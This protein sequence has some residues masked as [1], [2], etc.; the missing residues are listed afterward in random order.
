[1]KKKFYTKSINVFLIIVLLSGLTKTMKAQVP[2]NY[3]DAAIGL[4]GTALKT[5]LHDITTTGHVKLTYAGLWTAYATTDVYPSPNNTKIWDIYSGDAASNAAYSGTAPY[6]LIY[7]T[8]QDNGTGSVEGEF[9]NREHTIPNSWWGG[10]DQFQYTDLNCLLATDKIVNNKRSSYPYGEVGTISWTSQNGSLLGT[11]NYPGISGTV[12]EPIDIF[13]GDAARIYFYFA[14]RYKDEIPGWYSVEASS[15]DIDVVFQSNGEFQTAYY[16]MLLSWH[17]ADP[18]SAKE[19]AR[20]DAVYNTN[21]KNANPF[22]D[23]PEFACDIWGGAGCTVTI[24]PQPDNYPTLFTA[25]DISDSRIDLSWTDAIGTNLPTGYLILANTTGTFTSPVDGTDPTADSDL[26]DGSALVKVAH[27]AKG[28]YSFSGLSATTQYYFQIYPYANSGTNIDFKTNPTV[29]ADDVTTRAKDGPVA[30][31]NE[32]HYDNDGTDSG[33]KIEIVIV[34]VSSYTLNNFRIDLYNGSDGATY[35]NETGSN[36]TLGN[37]SGN[38]TIYTWAYVGI[39]NGAPDGV[40]LS[41]N[42]T[43]IQFLSYEGSFDATNGTANGT[44]STDIGVSEAGTST[45]G[46]SL[47]LSGTGCTYAD[48]TWQGSAANTMGAVN[49]SQ[50]LCSAAAPEIN[51]QGNSTTIVDEDGTPALSD[52][53]DFGSTDLASGSVVRTFTIQ[54]TGSAAL[55]LT[56]SSPYVTIGGAHAADFSVTTVPSTSIAASGSTTFQ[57]TFN[58]SATGTRAAT[59]SIANSDSNENPY[60]FSIQGTGTSPTITLTGTDPGPANFVQN[61]SNN[62]FYRIKVDVAGGTDQNVTHVKFD[63][64]STGANLDALVSGYTLW[65]STDATLNTGTDSNLGT[66]LPA[67]TTNQANITF[68]FSGTPVSITSG[69][70]GYFFITTSVLLTANVG[71]TVQATNAGATYTTNGGAVATENFAAGNAHTIVL[72]RNTESDIITAG[73]EAVSV[74]S[75]ENDAA[76]TTTADGTQVWQF[77]TRD[78]GSDGTDADVL[79]TI[80]NA[81][82]ISQ[83]SGNALQQWDDIILACALF[84]GSTK[85]ADAVIPAA[86]NQIQF[87]GAPLISV[88]DNGS[89]TLSLRLS[90]QTSPN[91]EGTNLDGEDFVFQISQG[92]VTAD[93]GGSGF[94]AFTATTS[95]NGAN[96]FDVIATK[97]LFVQQPSDVGVNAVMSPAPAIEA[98]DTHGTRD[99]DFTGNIQLTSTGTMTGTTNPAAVAG[100]A[101]F[102]NITHTVVETN[103]TLSGTSGVLSGTGLSSEFDVL[104]ITVLGQ[105]DL[106]ILAVNTNIGS[107][108]GIDQIAF[109]CFQD[110]LPGTKILLTDNG[111]ERVAAGYWGGTEGVITIERTTST[112]TAGTIIVLESNQSVITDATHFTVYTCGASDANWTKG[113]ISGGSGFGVNADDQIWIMQGGTWTNSTSHYSTYDGNVLYGWSENGWKSAPGYDD[114]KGSTL[115][116]GSKCFTTDVSGNEKVKFDDPI[117][118]DFSTSTN[119]RLDWIALVNDN[120]NWDTYADNLAY[121]SGGYNYKG[122]TTCPA[123]IIDSNPYSAGIWTGT[124]NTDWFDCGNWQ[125]LIVPDASINVTVSSMVANDIIIDDASA[126]AA[127]YDNLAECQDLTLTELVDLQINAADRLDVHGNLSITNASFTMT[128][129]SILNLYG[130]FTNN[131]TTTEFVESTGTVNLLGTVGQSINSSDP[132]NETFYNLVINNSAP[133][134]ITLNASADVDGQLTHTNGLLDLNGKALTISGIYARTNGEFKGNSASNLTIDGAGTVADLY[135]TA[136]QEL[137]NFVLSRAVSLNLQTNIEVYDELNII[138]GGEIADNGKTITVRNVADINGIHSGTGKILLSNTTTSPYALQGTG[139]FGNLEMNSAGDDALIGNVIN[140]N[141]FT[142]TAG[143]SFDTGNKNM[144]V[145]GDL[146]NNVSNLTFL[147]G[148]GTVTFNGSATQTITA[149][150]GQEFYNLV[151]DNATETDASLLDIKNALTINSGD[152]FTINPGKNVTVTG[153]ITNTPGTSGLILKSDASGTASLLHSTLNI[154]ATCERYL[155]ADNWHYLFTPLNDANINILTTNSGGYDNPNFYWYDEPTPDY[156]LGSTVYNP[157]GWTAPAHNGK[158]LTDIGYIHRSTESLTYNLSGG[159]LFA[160]TKNF[161]LSYTDNG[162]GN[163]THTGKDWNYFEGWN[164]FGNPYPSAIDWNNAGIVKT[165]IENFVYYYD[166]TNDQYKC[167]GGS[168]PWDNGITVNGGSQYIPANQGFF[169]KATGTGVHGQTF[170]IPNTARVHNG[171]AFWKAPQTEI[172]NLCRLQIE[173]DNYTDEIVIRTDANATAEHDSQYDAYKMFAWDASKPQLFSRNDENSNLYAVNTLPEV[174]QNTVVPLGV[175]IGLAGSY[176]LNL[177]KNNFYGIH[178]YLEDADLEQFINLRENPIYTF[179][180]SAQMNTNRF[181]LHFGLNTA[182]VVNADIPN[183]TILSGTQYSYS[184]PSNL[185]T[186]ADFGDSISIS[187]QL[188]NGNALPEWLTFD[189]QSMTFSGTPSEIQIYNIRLRASD[190]FGAAASEDFTLKVVDNTSEISDINSNFLI[191]PNPAEDILNIIAPCKAT[192]RIYSATGRYISSGVI[193]SKETAISLKDQAAGV[194]IIELRTDTGIFKQNII[195]K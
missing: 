5:E 29:P 110:I 161:T 170:S 102:S 123:L 11:S 9:Y 58:P 90:V 60:N 50:T 169:V 121:N 129:G 150:N 30:W 41:Y 75:L 109:V 136:P 33:E 56:G 114:P 176:S 165:Y 118:P 159:N 117:D 101:T 49:N 22:I 156:W 31:I 137:N 38:A 51:I 85:L 111:Y 148:T 70:S 175:Q 45:V 188:E 96:V 62:I 20:N 24:L 92:N 37:T 138:A 86:G 79:N 179:N 89:V 18:P 151:I 40:A 54:N 130:N 44:T 53:T 139:N 154:P 98:T 36:F 16:N 39:Q 194:Y 48:F 64:V 67:A 94:A 134:G 61:S 185:F 107:P 147:E 131:E 87:S 19:T 80:V 126:E 149:P 82:T 34:D 12:F 172:P 186:D 173:K 122:N 184:A 69:T 103:R 84:N 46:H 187:A 125:T 83:A 127:L 162:T 108:A 88:P 182:P 68:D 32:I 26:S 4:T 25:T 74:S 1:M 146:T 168:V 135:F 66:K 91:N 71:S 78:G 7:G 42:G 21:Q 145:T 164:L 167:Y 128:A 28:S 152:V 113:Y 10:T 47:Q 17:L 106:A 65:Y 35:A 23:H 180:Q 95:L 155:S 59:L 178:V 77:T 116:P 93:A 6:Y 43:L 163:E 181:F 76:I 133:S 158:L 112:L 191:Y 190:I 141:N 73:N 97:L 14:C 171:Q 124:Q 81:I 142:I 177:T 8:D 166:D 99:L 100:I 140:V 132:A 2:A 143:N 119:S 192:Y 52:H 55:S 174:T 3:Y 153:T 57:I 195:K 27:G 183:Q 157:T 63:A 193:Q 104:N 160:G 144:N 13:K 15:T 189:A 120:A 115:Y 72:L 105:G